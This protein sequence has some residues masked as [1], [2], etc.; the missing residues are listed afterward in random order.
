MRSMPVSVR[1][2]RQRRVIDKTRHPPG[3]VR[4]N[5]VCI[6]GIQPRVRNANR[7]PLPAETALFGDRP[8]CDLPVIPADK[9]GRRL[10]NQ[11]RCGAGSIQSTAADWARASGW[12]GDSSARMMVP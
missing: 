4:V 6:A 3:H 8:R 5:I 11:F 2:I 10:V 9:L 1:P 7:D 12:P